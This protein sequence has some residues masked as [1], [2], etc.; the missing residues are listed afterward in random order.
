MFQ[1]SPAVFLVFIQTNC[2]HG[3]VESINCAENS[4][5]SVPIY[6]PTTP[7]PPPLIQ[8][9]DI[10]TQILIKQTII[11]CCLSLAKIRLQQG[12]VFILGVVAR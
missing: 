3:H 7:P 8:Q 1:K 5:Y 9:V 11:L 2:Y 6:T 12:I 4:C 10:L